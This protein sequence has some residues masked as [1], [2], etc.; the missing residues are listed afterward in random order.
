MQLW[1]RLLY[2]KC[3]IGWWNLVRFL[4]GCYCC[5]SARWCDR[6]NLCLLCGER[7]L[8]EN[9]VIAMH[10]F[11]SVR[12]WQCMLLSNS[13]VDDAGLDTISTFLRPSEW[14]TARFRIKWWRSKFWKWISVYLNAND[15]QFIW[16]TM[17]FTW[18]MHVFP[19]QQSR[20]PY[21]IQPEYRMD[22]NGDDEMLQ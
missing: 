18:K 6:G 15:D 21:C 7:W 4:V 17:E 1:I 12:C 14:M 3:Q 11:S 16:V 9:D 2:T 8:A 19:H 13:I 20:Y 10:A 5:C 22:L